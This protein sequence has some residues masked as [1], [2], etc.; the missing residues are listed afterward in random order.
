MVR[1][2]DRE[3][4]RQARK[5]QE[6]EEQKLEHD[7]I[8]R[9]I[10][11]LQQQAERLGE[12]GKVDEYMKISAQI[13]KLKDQRVDNQGPYFVATLLIFPVQLPDGVAG[14]VIQQHGRQSQQQ[15][16]KVCEIC[17][18][19]LSKFDSDARLADH[20][21]GKLHSGFQA[22]R[23]K[24]DELKVSIFPL[25]IYNCQSQGITSPTEDRRRY[26]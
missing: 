5:L 7:P 14:Q 9:Q 15:K 12:E 18:C 13:E 6:E 23:E 3:V 17:G 2:C 19:F 21:K 4:E 11:D 16:L 1:D 10:A 26:V 8:S 20:F 24:I 25:C 22:I